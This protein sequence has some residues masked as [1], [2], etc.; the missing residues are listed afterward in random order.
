LK[1]LLTS[2]GTRGDIEPF[3][4]I[5]ELLVKKGHDVIFSFPQQFAHVIG[6]EA[7]FHAL[8]PRIIELIE[9]DEGRAVMG[10]A[11]LLAKVRAI[12]HL[13]KEGMQVNRE[14]MKQQY[15]IIEKENL[16][17]IIHNVKC[18]YPLLWGLKHNRRTVLVSPVPYF[19][20][21]VKGHSHI[22]FNKDFGTFLNKLT[23]KISNFGLVKTIHDAQKYLPK[24]LTFSKSI[25]KKALFSKQLIYTISP[26]LFQ[27]P[28]YWADNVQVLGYHER[29]KIMD[30]KPDRA[31][32]QFLETHSKVLFLT[33][34]SMVNSFPEDISWLIYN[35]LAKLEVAV[36]VNTAA[37]GL[38]KI[39]EFER[40]ENFYFTKQIPYEWIL[41]R[42]YAVV[43]HGGSGTTHSALKYGC[44]TLIIPHIIDQFGWNNLIAKIQV[45]P[46]GLS[47]NKITAEK[48]RELLIDLLNN[49]KYRKKSGQ[50]AMK[51]KE[52]QLEVELYDFIIGLD[53]SNK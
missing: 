36:I 45:G 10:K 9:S 21:Y 38:I 17:L 42:V 52:E 8:S 11:T 39:D 5:G 30:W 33:F 18:N 37:G 19:I 4:A 46:K 31:L 14:L 26:Q 22:G 6:K 49:E 29:N 51:M 12:I 16:D 34:G 50:I 44:P 35:V 23:Y 53:S 41:S 40:E 13:Y 32:N 1:V 28:N 2:I 48:F 20:N 47:I 43:H 15:E 3:L 7:T 27:R 24:K 25:I